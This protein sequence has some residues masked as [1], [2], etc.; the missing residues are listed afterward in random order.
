[1]YKLILAAAIFLIPCAVQAQHHAHSGG[2]HMGGHVGGY[3]GHVGFG[4]HTA[5]VVPHN[6][7]YHNNYYYRPYNYGFGIGFGF[8]NPYYYRP[9]YV[10][11]PVYVP[12]PTP[13]RQPRTH[14]QMRLNGMR[15]LTRDYQDVTYSF[16]NRRVPVINGYVP[17]VIEKTGLYGDQIIIYDYQARVSWAEVQARGKF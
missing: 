8:Y 1:M 11:Q 10:P 17:N 3:G 9:Y 2:V 13:V 7:Y 14:I 12:V 4:Y 5:P 6:Y 15:E 16:G